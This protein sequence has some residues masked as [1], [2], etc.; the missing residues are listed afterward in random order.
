MDTGELGQ[1]HTPAEGAVCP[2]SLPLPLSEADMEAWQVLRTVSVR[3]GDLLAEDLANYTDLS[4][5]EHDVLMRLA[6]AEDTRLRMSLLAKE[7]HLSPS[8]LS[9]TVERLES[10]GLVDRLSCPKDRRGVECSLTHAG[11][12]VLKQSAAKY[13]ATVKERVLSNYSEEELVQITSLLGRLT[14]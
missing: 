14:S 6:D 5:S 10:R 11:R 3:L 8:R 12:E 9:H 7:V 13:F 2:Q 1:G 4:V